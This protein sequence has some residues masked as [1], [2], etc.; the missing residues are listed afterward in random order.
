MNDHLMSKNEEKITTPMI[1]ISFLTVGLVFY[2]FTLFLKYNE[3]RAGS[4]IEDLVLNAFS[5]VENNLLIFALTYG[6]VAL[7][8]S[9]TLVTRSGILTANLG[10]CFL[11]AMR[12]LTLYYFPL[13]PPKSIIP[14]EDIFLQTTFYSQQTLLKDL[15]FSGHTAAVF[16]LFFLVRNRVIKS[17]LI[18][19]GIM[20]GTLL[21]S[22]HVHYTIDVVLAPIF[23]WFAYLA[24]VYAKNWVVNSAIEFPFLRPAEEKVN[25]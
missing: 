13:E 15:F 20:L 23:S 11:I 25:M 18:V 21:L 4:I 7:G 19:G 3:T 9:F 1:I 24:A 10:I 14:L 2:I 5:P 12:M 22:Q 6:L 16:L 17:I 8:L